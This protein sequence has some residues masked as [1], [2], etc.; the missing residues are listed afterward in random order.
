MVWVGEDGLDARTCPLPP[1]IVSCKGS[2]V[3][4][5]PLSFPQLLFHCVYSFKVPLHLCLIHFCH[6]TNLPFPPVNS[7][8]D[9]ASSSNLLLLL[10]ILS[11]R[12]ERRPVKGTP[13]SWGSEVS[14]DKAAFTKATMSEELKLMLSNRKAFT[15]KIL[16]VSHLECSKSC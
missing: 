9:C 4:E 2:R 10:G 1:A 16:W 12:L 8:S 6:F 3:S 5:E 15:I 7:S 14:H 13:D 11:S